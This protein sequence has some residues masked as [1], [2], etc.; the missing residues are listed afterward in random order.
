MATCL[1]VVNWLIALTPELCEE[2]QKTKNIQ[3][4]IKP[5]CGP[6]MAHGPNFGY[7][8]LYEHGKQMNK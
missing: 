4:H 8:R 7:D 1:M 6:Q 5:V 2:K 3:N